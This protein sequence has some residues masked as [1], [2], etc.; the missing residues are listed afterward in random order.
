MSF[1][2]KLFYNNRSFY[3]AGVGIPV[4]VTKGRSANAM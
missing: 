2:P 4:E 1:I 3:L